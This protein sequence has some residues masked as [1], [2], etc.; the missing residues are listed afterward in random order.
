MTGSCALLL[1]L[2]FPAAAAAQSPSGLDWYRCTVVLEP[3]SAARV[4]V[5]DVLRT[6][7]EPVVYTLGR[8][9]DSA[10][11]D[12][13]F[14]SEGEETAWTTET[15]EGLTRYVIGGPGVAFRT[16]SDRS[17]SFT[18]TTQNVPASAKVR[19]ARIFENVGTFDDPRFETV[20][21][22][23]IGGAGLSLGRGPI[24]VVMDARF[25]QGLSGI[26]SSVDASGAH[27][28]SWAATL[29]IELR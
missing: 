21:W 27:N 24:R 11:S 2:V 29:G 9:P 17:V 28:A 23:V 18:T 15:L 8:A 7:G 10:I 22:S 3:G 5:E 25:T 20:D 1:M 16:G 14:R 6:G 26:Y 19:Y 13:T 4:V 12:V